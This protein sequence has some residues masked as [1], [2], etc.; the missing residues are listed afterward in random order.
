MFFYLLKVIRV[1]LMKHG[2][3]KVGRFPPTLAQLHNA[4]WIFRLPL[5]FEWGCE[6][7]PVE[8]HTAKA[9]DRCQTYA[10]LTPLFRKTIIETAILISTK[11]A[12]FSRMAATVRVFRTAVHVS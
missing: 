2:I 4:R 9:F 6:I 8:G 10:A 3:R 5:N 11:I 7:H 12:L 1:Y